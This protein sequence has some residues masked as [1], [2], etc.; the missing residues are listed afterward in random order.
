MWW[1]EKPK[2]TKCVYK[3]FAVF[4]DEELYIQDW[5]LPIMVK[6]PSSIII[7]DKDALVKTGEKII[8]Y[9]W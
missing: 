2:S 9:Y 3:E 7:K 1:C 6:V 8:L 5:N 4:S